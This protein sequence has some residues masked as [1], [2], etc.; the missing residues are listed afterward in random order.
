LF[1]IRLAAG[2][3]LLVDG[4]DILHADHS[5]QSII[6]GWVALGDGALL[7]AGLWTPFAG[8]LLVLLAAW[9]ILFQ[10]YPPY[11]NILLSSMGAAI[12]LI[13]PGAMSIDAWLFGWK[14]IELDN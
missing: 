4:I 3:S 5:T 6:L 2:S 14:K 13:G 7:L 11:P 9:E 12:A 1:L 10:H 8:C